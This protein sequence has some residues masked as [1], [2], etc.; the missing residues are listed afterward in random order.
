MTSKTIYLPKIDDQMATD[1]YREFFM[2]WNPIEAKFEWTQ[3]A[4]D[5]VAMLNEQLVE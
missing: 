1:F 5:F 2:Q 3:A 4:V